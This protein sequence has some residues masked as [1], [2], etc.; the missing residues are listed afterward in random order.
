MGHPV[1]I[2]LNEGEFAAL[3][4]LTVARGKGATM[5]GIVKEAL[6]IYMRQPRTRRVVGSEVALSRRDS[7]RAEVERVQDEISR[8]L[9]LASE[10]QRTTA[11]P[12]RGSQAP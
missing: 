5:A 12:R 10:T 11:A 4:L 1:Q 2:V 7:A 8:Y 9:K 3:K 6:I